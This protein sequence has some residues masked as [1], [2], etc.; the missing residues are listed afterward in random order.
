MKRKKASAVLLAAGLAFCASGVSVLAMPASSAVNTLQTGVVDIGI[1][2][3]R[4]GD[5]TVSPGEEAAQSFTITNAGSECWIR[6][7]IAVSESGSEVYGISDEWVLAADGCYYYTEAVSTG[8]AVD[9]SEGL[10]VSENLT[11]EDAGAE[12]TVSVTAEA[13]QAANF[14]PDFTSD[15]PW[16]SISIEEC[17]ADGTYDIET[18]AGRMNLTVIYNGAAE[19]VI[20]DPEDF[21]TNFPS[22]MP[23]D[24]YSDSVSL[25]NYSADN[26]DLYFRAATDDEATIL[27]AAELTI[28]CTMDGET[29]TVYEGTLRAESMADNTL[30]ASI[31]SGE[32]GTLDFT[33]TVPET[34]GN[35]YAGQEASVTWTFSAG[36]TGS[37]ASGSG[38][39]GSDTSSGVKTGDTNR[40]GLALLGTGAGLAGI[41]FATGRKRKVKEEAR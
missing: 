21:F 12:I 8:E 17:M 35:S 6:A 7:R 24:V 37:A 1:E 11:A 23:G 34:L 36:T 15:S 3:S 5:G 25:A 14:T 19:E 16:G 22:L 28:T 32:T 27:D 38:D 39:E 4:E 20:T 2:G 29:T 26:I 40:L 18:T 33:I 30:L 10:A 41:A 9:L 13:V 31:P